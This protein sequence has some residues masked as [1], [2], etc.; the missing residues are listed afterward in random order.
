M[1]ALRVQI[2]IPQ[3]ISTY[4]NPAAMALMMVASWS[5]SFNAQT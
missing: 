3:I 2:A 4:F 1:V 5:S